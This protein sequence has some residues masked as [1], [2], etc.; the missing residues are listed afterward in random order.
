MAKTILVASGK[1]GTG[2]TTTSA[3]IALEMSYQKHRVLLI[4]TDCGFKGLDI[5][6]GLSDQI[7]YNF[8]DVLNDQASIESAVVKKNRYLHLLSAPFMQISRNYT[9]SHI[10]KMI[11]SVFDYYDYIIVDC[12][13]GYTYETEIFAKI[14]NIALIITSLDDTSI[15]AAENMACKLEDLGLAKCFLVLSRVRPRLVLKRNAKNIDEAIDA[16][17]LPLLGVIPEDENVIACGNRG[18]PVYS[19]PRSQS[20]I[21][22][23]NI[24]GRLLGENV[25]IMKLR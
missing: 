19:M 22:Y 16:T 14:S 12:A 23:K 2:K 18:L 15:R 21:A 4:D 20:A 10:A 6:L 5:V 9:V 13:A 24:T 3:H 1:G 11:D 25:N 8:V 17:C 7:L